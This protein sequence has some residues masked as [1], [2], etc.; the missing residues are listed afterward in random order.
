MGLHD[1]LEASV[2]AHERSERPLVDRGGVGLEE[3]GG[4]DWKERTNGVSREVE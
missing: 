3:G 4:D 1:A 2:I